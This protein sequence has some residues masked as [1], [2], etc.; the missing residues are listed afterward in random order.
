VERE[1]GTIHRMKQWETALVILSALFAS[2][3]LAEDFKTINGPRNE[4]QKVASYDGSEEYPVKY[5]ENHR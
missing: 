3:A 5:W 4:R 1:S 2:F